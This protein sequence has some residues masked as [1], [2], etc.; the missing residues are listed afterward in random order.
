M[1]NKRSVAL[2]HGSLCWSRNTLR[3]LAWINTFFFLFLCLQ[4]LVAQA[5]PTG[6]T[7]V[8]GSGA[9]TIVTD[10]S[11]TNIT[12]A[13]DKAIINWNDF[14][15][16]AGEQVNFN[17]LMGADSVTLNR[18]IGALPSNI[19]GQLTANGRIFLLNPNGIL[20]GAGSSIDVAGLMAS[21]F[22][23]SDDDFL[24]GKYDFT[25]D[26][27]KLASYVVNNGTITVDDHG[28]VYLVAPGVLNSGL[29]VAQLG[30][31]LLGSGNAFT[32]NFDGGGLITYEV[33]GKVL[34]QVIG[35]DGNPLSSAV[36]NTG[37]I[38]SNGGNVVLTGS[39]A[40]DI[41]ASAVN[42]SGIIEAKSMT[43]ADGMVLLSG[44][45]EGDVVTNGTIDVSA[46]EA[47]A[48]GG[49]IVINSKDDVVVGGTFNT[50]GYIAGNATVDIKASDDV[51][52][53]EALTLNGA[54]ATLAMQA[55]RSVLINA[56][57]T[58]DDGSVYLTANEPNSDMGYRDP[59]GIGSITMAT[60]TT[61]DAGTG[62]IA[63]T[64]AR[65]GSGDYVNAGGMTISNIVSDG[66]EV[67]LDSYDTISDGATAG[68][69]NITAGTLNMRVAKA[70]A[71]IGTEGNA[72]RV[73]A[74]TLNAQTDGG[75]IIVKDMADGVELGTVSTWSGT[76]DVTGTV[77]L[78]A[79]GGD[80]TA[81]AVPGNN[82]TAYAATLSTTQDTVGGIRGG[83]IGTSGNNLKTDVVVLAA[84]TDNGS[85][86]ITE[87][88]GVIV[89]YLNARQDGKTAFKNEFG[90]VVIDSSGTVGTNGVTL[91]AGGD[92]LLGT[93]TA[94]G[95]ANIT[96]GGNIYDNQ[97]HET[98]VIARTLNFSAGGAVGQ[99]SNPLET[100]VETINAVAADGGVFITD[101]GKVTVG[102][103]TAAGDENDVVIISNAGDVRL[104]TISGGTVTVESKQGRLV[105]NNGTALNITADKAVLRAA[106][107]IGTSAADAD[108]DTSVDELDA[109]V[110]NVGAPIYINEQDGLTEVTLSTNNGNVTVN[111]AGGAL[112]F[113]AASS[114]LTL[115]AM[116]D[117]ALSFS[118]TGG[119]IVQQG[120]NIGSADLVLTASGAIKNAAGA[121]SITAGTATLTA[122][123]YIGT[124]DNAVATDVDELI[125]TAGNGGIFI[126]EATAVTL[127]AT[128]SGAGSSIRVTNDAGDMTLKQV[129][130]AGEIYLQT[131]GNLIDGNGGA[132]NI[133][134]S[135]A[136]L[137]AGVAIGAAGDA[138][139]TNV[140][141]LDAVSHNGGIFLA[142]NR[143]LSSLKAN[144][145]GG[146]I[147]ISSTGSMTIGEL[148]AGGQAITLVAGGDI[149]DGNGDTVNITAIKADLTGRKIGTSAD[150]VE[151]A[152]DELVIESTNGGIFI[153]QPGDADLK[154]TSAKAGGS[155]SN[156]DI[157][158]R[159][160]ISLGTVES[161]GN[162]VRLE[163]EEG[164][165]T[166]GRADGEAR[167]NVKAKSL[168]IVAPG[169]LGTEA[170]PL[171]FE[172]SFLSADG[173]GVGVAA[174]NDGPLAITA[175]SLVGKG[176]SVVKIVADKITVL[177][178]GGSTITMDA[179]GSLTLI[180]STGDIVFL[181]QDDTIDASGG[182]S[183]TLLAGWDSPG[184]GAVI[185]AGNLITTDGG[186]IT[187][188]ADSHITIG[189]LDAGYNVGD[190]WVE[191]R[192]GIILDGNGSEANIIAGIATLIGKTPTAEEAELI[193]EQATAEYY[194]A[195]A[196]AAAKQTIM[197]T[198]SINSATL[199]ALAMQAGT[200]RNVAQSDFSSK[201]S[202]FNS[203]NDTLLAMYITLTVLQGVKTGLQVASDVAGLIGAGAQAI[204][205]TGDGGASVVAEA[206]DV[207]F[208]V[209]DLALFAFQVVYDQYE[210]TVSGLEG[211][212]SAAAANLWAATQDQ[213]MATQMS[214]AAQASLGVAQTAYANAVIAEDH[215][216]V[217]E[218]QAIAA[219]Q[220]NNVIGTAA[221]PLGIEAAK[222]N[223]MTYNQ[224][225]VYLESPGKLGLG[226]ISSVGA[227]SQV[228]VNA[229]GDINVIGQVVGNDLIKIESTGGAILDG[230]G[231]LIAPELLAVAD[232]GIGGNTG[233][234]TKVDRLAAD[235][236]NGGVFIRNDNGD[237]PLNI[238]TVDG[239][240]GVSGAGD[241]T[242]DTT[243]NLVLQKEITDTAGVNDVTLISRG[244]AVIDDNGLSM[245]VT[246]NTLTVN[247][248]KDDIN[249][250]T[251][252][253]VLTAE[254]GTGSIIIRE[255][256]AVNLAELTA[257]NGDVAV[258]A[259]GTIVVR[260]VTAGGDVA[261]TATGAI[262]DDLDD[263]TR[264]T[265]DQLTLTA[266]SGIGSAGPAVSRSLDTDV[267]SLSAAV[268]TAGAINISE[269]NG[270]DILQAI[271]P[272]GDIT[273]A[274]AAGNL[275][276][277][278]VAAGAAGNTVTLVASGGAITDAVADEAA[279]ISA[280]NLA[281]SAAA[282]I[283][284][285]SGILEITVDNMVAAGGSGGIYIT[286]LAGGLTIGGVTPGLA[287][288]DVTGLQATGGDI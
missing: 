10:G 81:A 74:D 4:P 190:V 64:V 276:L 47:G 110:G 228:L 193:R 98:D 53:D 141:G 146:D 219:A 176:S 170:D 218:L 44:R 158:A 34:D 155:G 123:T 91:N 206:V 251:D 207:A 287:N 279:K 50:G 168:E 202:A 221:Q 220:I 172:T 11:N 35:S 171:I 101:A 197:D 177:D 27:T 215:A 66:G 223:I 181:N 277:T 159:K 88:D 69:T 208:S 282:G 15:I 113:T 267:N 152:V 127:T 195:I 271:T 12:Q 180:A 284:G 229:A 1:K 17:Q 245:N 225:S 147:A 63:M 75:H 150:K 162:S 122:G 107:G 37:T 273:I 83:A 133:T 116:P 144:A 125:L 71:T 254:T 65:S 30:Q 130:A 270:L 167:P 131:A 59:A 241:I 7:V 244:G 104:G 18:V 154:L 31:V 120:V 84:A 175:D 250:D 102:A 183:I 275:N 78:E 164:A 201:E 247:A 100:M 196:E 259:G 32:M 85:I 184:S 89:N 70:G 255:K 134:G 211:D 283:G 188:K 261:L 92:I 16:G 187:L 61:I 23:I 67:T 13:T 68:T 233:I 166:D 236:G 169:G 93:V 20:F 224:S 105:D 77:I 253:A 57:I 209:A 135:S 103:I 140:A 45:E 121:G 58:T 194:A 149:I 174:A 97:Q 138:I 240:S 76:G 286:D 117:M 48:N 151:I 26:P 14:S 204:P 145:T 153:Y 62:D 200:V 95:T 52:V 235:G 43:D 109:V 51:V 72:L 186:S 278:T 216:G 263:T 94:P 163:S 126:S 252:I 248:A 192:N 132:V 28:F 24:S 182:G 142:N 230:G 19:L 118:N 264:I 119:D 90:N 237:V 243:G 87:E 115:P 80:I 265:G 143:D 269:A 49:R 137:N 42:N 274:A 55:G 54:G 3:R 157:A 198:W 160:N 9:A 205:L 29:I 108:I 189:R 239:V 280:T 256:S 139:E 213:M 191:S 268:N 111:F 165:I 6:G 249:L 210:N 226:D 222:V 25:Q 173:G 260:T 231:L 8:P 257:G 288:P 36:S 40:R 232:N 2:Y 41:I 96:A 217:V 99:D 22:N 86:F 203:A 114:L 39:T 136:V 124:T 285:S 79:V 5:A 82:I 128:A 272:D 46:G 258:T 33:S 112:T 148:L 129:A 21:T 266:Q 214:A 246:A 161:V 262:E 60:G 73:D 178:N 212:M 185:V 179:G 199:T 156:I 234:A 238:T 38:R 56:D 242:L 106:T 281:L 227:G